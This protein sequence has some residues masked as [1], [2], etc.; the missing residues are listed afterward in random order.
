MGVL[1]KTVR[2]RREAR[3][4]AICIGT[5]ESPVADDEYGVTDGLLKFSSRSNGRAMAARTGVIEPR[6]G[7]SAGTPQRPKRLRCFQTDRGGGFADIG[8]FFPVEESA[9]DAG[10]HAGCPRNPRADGWKTWN[11]RAT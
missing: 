3:L 7:V 9:G 2:G 8:E 5:P 11:S 4:A 1:A 6:E 10:M